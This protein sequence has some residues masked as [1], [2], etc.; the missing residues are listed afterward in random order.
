MFAEIRVTEAGYARHG[1]HELSKEEAIDDLERANCEPLY[2]F[3]DADHTQYLDN[4]LAAVMEDGVDV[5][6]Y[7][8]W[9][10]VSLTRRAKH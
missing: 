6:S 10:L 2:A 3:A 1:E 5:R 8:G 9:T 4:L 7:F